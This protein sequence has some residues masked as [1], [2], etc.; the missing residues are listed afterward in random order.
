MDH[1]SKRKGS[2]ITR[3]LEIL[4]TLAQSPYP[5]S[6]ADLAIALDIPKPSIHRLLNTL[7]KEGYV[8][9]DSYGGF[10]VGNKIHNLILNV[11]KSAPLKIERMSILEQLSNTI[12]ETCGIAVMYDNHMAYTD[13]VQT[14]WPLQIYLPVGSKV[15]LWCTSSGKLFLSGLEQEQR[16]RILRSLPIEKMTNNT[17]IDL[18]QLN[19]NL[20]QIAQQQFSTD[21]EEFIAGMVAMSVPIVDSQQDLI[22]CLYTHAPTVRKSLNDLLAFETTLRGAA[23]ELSQLIQNIQSHKQVKVE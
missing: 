6:P 5:L 3:V 18:P 4:D 2:S 17:I 8:Q 1:D 23:Q 7:D 20:D 11:W 13:R 21:N 12:G 22:A 15:P 19:A 14:N 10:T 9:L 16:N